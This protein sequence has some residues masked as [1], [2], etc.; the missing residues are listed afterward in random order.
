MPKFFRSKGNFYLNNV[1][2]Y[3][4]LLL[5]FSLIKWIK[6]FQ[7]CGHS[8]GQRRKIREKN[9]NANEQQQQKIS[10]EIEIEN[11]WDNASP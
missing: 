4:F 9:C 6:K 10:T 7:T 8:F 11:Y 5:L 2:C 1:A 3:I